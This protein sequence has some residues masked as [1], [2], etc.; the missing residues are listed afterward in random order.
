MILVLTMKSDDRRVAVNSA[1]IWKFE[2]FLH[3]NHPATTAINV[4]ECYVIVKEQF[5]DIV[6]ALR[7]NNEEKVRK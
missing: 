4:G 2:E 1:H 7:E 3:P 5:D 6:K